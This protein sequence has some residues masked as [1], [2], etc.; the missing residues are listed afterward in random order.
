MESLDG[1][2]GLT[3]VGDLGLQITGNFSLKN[4]SA[5]SA[6]TAIDGDLLVVFNPSLQSLSGF[7]NLQ[8]L[9]TFGT[10]VIAGNDS[11]TD[12][13]G[14]GALTTV[15]RLFIEENFLLE[16][17]TG[18]ENLVSVADS[19]SVSGNYHLLNLDGLAGL[20]SIG[21]GLLIW[22]D[23]SLT[24][25]AGLSSLN[26]IGGTVTITDSP[27]LETCATSEIC[28]I[29]KT[30]PVEAVAISGNKAGCATRAE[31][32]LGCVQLPVRLISFSA[33]KEGGAALLEWATSLETN[34]DFFEIQH[35]NATGKAWTVIGKMAAQGESTLTHRYTFVH[36]NPLMGSNLYRLKMVDQ[37]G[38]FAYSSI[39]HV[40]WNNVAEMEIFPNPVVSS[41]ILR[42][43]N[44]TIRRIE[45][46]NTAGGRVTFKSTITQAAA[47]APVTVDTAHLPAGLYVVRIAYADGQEQTARFVKK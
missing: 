23:S 42:P 3:T 28:E 40:R 20:Q 2:N 9:G 35:S 5:L 6:L 39:Q 7:D 29:L 21:G 27:E 4:V 41:L 18:I 8:S 25:L 33:R 44:R 12:L 26:A 11:L 13:Q 47:T 10:L 34:S 14:L 43:K 1:L 38:S 16:E 31:V 37:D 45:L 46:Y 32:D 22:A 30:K 19:A 15:D 36:D 24:S 17:L